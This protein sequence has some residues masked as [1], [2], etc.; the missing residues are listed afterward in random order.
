MFTGLL[1][2]F[3]SLYWLDFG[4]LWLCWSFYRVKAGLIVFTGFYRV[5]PTFWDDPTKFNRV[6]FVLGLAEGSRLC[7]RCPFLVSVLL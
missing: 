5:F 1:P 4:F 7:F 3:Y 6:F 2:S